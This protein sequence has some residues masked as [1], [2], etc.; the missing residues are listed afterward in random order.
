MGLFFVIIKGMTVTNVTIPTISGTPRSGSTLTAN[1]GTWTFSQDYLTYNYQWLR[2]DASGNNCV[3]INNATNQTYVLTP[4]DIGSEIRVQVEALEHTSPIP[5]TPGSGLSA[6]YYDFDFV[7]I[8]DPPWT[9]V[10]TDFGPGAYGPGAG[11]QTST[12]GYSVKLVTAPDSV[13]RALRFELRD[14]SPPWPLSTDGKRSQLQMSEDQTWNGAPFAVGAER[15][16]FY[17]LYLP[18]NDPS[19]EYFDWGRTNWNTWIGLHPS[20]GNT[21]GQGWGCFDMGTDGPYTHPFYMTWKLAG[22]G[23]SNPRDTL[24]YPRL[25]QLTNADGSRYA[26]NYNRRIQ[27]LLGAK[28]N[29]T[30]AGGWYEGWVDGVNVLP[31][32]S[33]A[34]MWTGDTSAY[35]KCGPYKSSS[36]SSVFPTNGK[37]IMYFTRIQ[38]GLAP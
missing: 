29:P 8:A 12:D 21:S 33:H 11:I 10:Q 2:C 22:G 23:G 20:G 34:T 24:I 9:S 32:T 4:S 6:P 30:H 18:N 17:E 35:F 28:F 38:I 7:K 5:P 27:L 1:P 37:S 15:W 31:R 19:G 14:S 16:F 36:S 25:F 3:S 13:G 26:P